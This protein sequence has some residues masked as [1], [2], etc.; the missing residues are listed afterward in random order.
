MKR[1]AGGNI[2]NRKVLKM[3]IISKTID[4]DMAE[5]LDVVCMLDNIKEGVNLK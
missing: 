4:R 5:L 3:A 1:R 2:K